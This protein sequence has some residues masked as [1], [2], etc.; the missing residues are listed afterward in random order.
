MGVLEQWNRSVD[1]HWDYWEYYRDLYDFSLSKGANTF[2]TRC[3]YPFLY[4]ERLAKREFVRN[5]QLLGELTPEE[6]SEFER[7]SGNKYLS[8]V[9]S[10]H[11]RPSGPL[12]LVVFPPAFVAAVAVL[13]LLYRAHKSISWYFM[14]P[15]LSFTT[16][17]MLGV[18]LYRVKIP[19][20]IDCTN[21]ALQKRKAEV[22][23]EQKRHPTAKIA[24]LPD[25]KAQILEIVNQVRP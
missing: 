20:L 18:N 23:L 9:Y 13:P 2:L 21:F 14:V 8:H 19:E 15:I 5:M 1:Q 16:V 6:I 3:F 17:H 25:L 11:H 22:W 7:L 4:Q 12:P 10:Y 24:A